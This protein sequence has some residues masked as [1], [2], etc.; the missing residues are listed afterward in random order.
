M[1]DDRLST[2]IGLQLLL[3]LL[4][5]LVIEQANSTQETNQDLNVILSA[6]RTFL[7]SFRS[8]DPSG[9]TVDAPDPRLRLSACTTP[10]EV[11][12]A[13]G[14]QPIGR[15]LIKV[16]CSTPQPWTL[17]LPA[18]VATLVSVVVAARSL[19]R[20]QVIVPGD[21][22]LESRDANELLSGYLS[23]PN[24]VLGK[25]LSRPAA[26]GSVLLPNQVQ[27]KRVIRRGDRV[28]VLARSAGLTVRSTGTAMADAGVGDTI[29]VRNE[30]SKKILDGIVEGPG[31]VVVR[32]P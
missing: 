31:V 6:A 25:V 27:A 24:Q 1:D 14:S 22:V 7:M 30:S 10:L 28:S 11:S 9:I 26:A 4:G 5:F 15:T 17:Y 20:D 16:R 18:K 19:F 13:A 2:W 23:D 8:G 32:E 29:S 12:M 21:V 3:L